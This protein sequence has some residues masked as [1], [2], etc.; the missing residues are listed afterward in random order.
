[1]SDIVKSGS[2]VTT[3]ELTKAIRLQYEAV[4]DLVVTFCKFAK[5]TAVGSEAD[6][7]QAHSLREEATALAAAVKQ[8][9]PT[10]TW[11]WLCQIMHE[12]FLQLVAMRERN[13]AKFRR[14]FGSEDAIPETVKR[15]HGIGETPQEPRPTVGQLRSRAR[16]TRLL[17]K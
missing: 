3:L 4:Q 17:K 16:A 15:F 10:V 2:G 14:L 7:E 1:M 5:H 9:V 6:R 13:G 11:E 8:T 12:E